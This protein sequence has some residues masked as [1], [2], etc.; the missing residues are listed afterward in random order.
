[1]SDQ[2]RV[3]AERGQAFCAFE[4]GLGTQLIPDDP[5][6]TGEN[7]DYQIRLTREPDGVVRVAV[8]TDG[9]ADVVSVDGS[10]VT[11]DSYAIVGGLRATIYN[12]FP[13][14]GVDA[15]ISFMSDFE[16]QHG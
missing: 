6:G 8:L 2:A 1:M 7:D 4:S 15:L 5:A 10:A 9:L 11:P 3:L 14:E 12:A 16:Q 13:V